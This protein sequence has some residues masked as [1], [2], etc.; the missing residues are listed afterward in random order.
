MNVIFMG[1]PDFASAALQALID[2]GI[3]VSAVFTQPDKPKNRGMKLFP[4]PVKEL[5]LQYDIP[6]YQPESMKDPSAEEIVR[7]LE[8]DLLITAAYGQIL[9]QRILSIPQLGAINLHG[10]LLPLYRGASP[11]QSCILNGDTVTGVTVQYMSAR[12]DAGAVI[13][14]VST[15][16]GENETAEELFDRLTI[17]GAGLLC[18]VVKAFRA[19]P[20]P[21][22]EQNEALA[23]YCRKLDRSM[24]P[25]NYEQ[26]ARMVVKH[27]CGLY[28]WPGAT[29]ELGGVTLKIAAALVAERSC[30]AVPGAVVSAGKEGI[31][32]AGGDGKAVLI[33]R[34]Q[35]PGKKEMTAEAYLAGHKVMADG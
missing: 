10:S 8:P 20:L 32:V 23:T 11:V 22:E 7:S 2:G 17:L 12:M 3:A 14:S 26:S 31:A 35:P 28:P 4:S 19:G 27:V 13:D 9:P 15:P 21:A 6:V 18:R 33:T 29:T 34:L 30:S 1:T 5:A 16:I 25:V 24:S